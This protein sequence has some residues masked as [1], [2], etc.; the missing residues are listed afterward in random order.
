MG[1]SNKGFVHKIVVG[2]IIFIGFALA[3]ILPQYEKHQTLVKTRTAAERGKEIAFALD[4][5][6]HQ[7]KRF[8]TDFSQIELSFPCERNEDNTQLSCDDYTYRLENPTL[9]RIEHNTLPQWFEIDVENG[10]VAC[11]SEKDS[12]AGQHICAHAHVSETL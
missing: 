1:L 8:P 4:K 7:Y 5:Y 10:T 11:E 9:L 2:S 3:L 6:H 12:W